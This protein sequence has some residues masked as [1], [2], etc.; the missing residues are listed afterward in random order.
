[1]NR[2][3]EERIVAMYFD[4]EDFEKNAKQT[5]DT[6]GQLKKGL[7]L[8]DSAKGFEVF[9]K[10]GKTLNFDKANQSLTRMKTTIGGIGDK[11]KKAFRIGQQPIKE[12]EGFLNHLRGYVSKYIGFDLAG[13]IVNSLESAIRQLT[14][15]P[16]S[17]G[18]NQYQ[19]KM[20]SVK[21]IMSSTGASIS[22]VNQQLESMT[23]YANKTIYSL[24]DMTSNLGK[25]TNNGVELN[26]AVKAMEGI[27]NA[28]ADAG[29]SRLLWQCTTFH[30]LS[31]LAR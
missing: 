24:T 14:V 26:R 21:T 18:W 31:A 2:E 11:F 22:E 6:L 5:I 8:K 28:T 9:D 15:Q 29:R 1:M 13:K 20:D 3:V 27:A 16:V 19:S 7:D 23:E 10:I 12:A 4:N 17:A 25:F 30:R